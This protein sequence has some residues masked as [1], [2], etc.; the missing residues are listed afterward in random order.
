MVVRPCLS[1]LLN[2]SLSEKWRMKCN[3]W[4]LSIK[5]EPMKADRA[6]SQGFCCLPIWVEN[7]VL[8]HAGFWQTT[9]GKKKKTAFRKSLSALEAK[10]DMRK[11]R[12]LSLSAVF[13]SLRCF[14]WRKANRL[15]VCALIIIAFIFLS[16]LSTAICSMA[17]QI[18]QI[19]SQRRM[20]FVPSHG[21]ANHW[22]ADLVPNPRFF[23]PP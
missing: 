1:Y 19:T 2:L 5:S 3:G 23:S 20:A 21:K 13:K 6:L 8:K 9:K 11:F 10:K 16:S 22:Q 17:P 7:L 14:I 18:P 15:C 4:R 12:I